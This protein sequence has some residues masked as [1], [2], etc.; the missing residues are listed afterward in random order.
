M[1]KL[2]AS[3]ESLQL[4]HPFPPSSPLYPILI[5]PSLTPPPGFIFPAKSTFPSYSSPFILMLIFTICWDPSRILGTCIRATGDRC[6]VRRLALSL[7]LPH[8]TILE[9]MLNSSLF[10]SLYIPLLGSERRRDSYYAHNT[11]FIAFYGRWENQY[12][13]HPLYLS[14]YSLMSI[15]IL[16]HSPLSLPLIPARTE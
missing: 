1:P 12:L 4:L 16:L 11:C 8:N 3:W 6:T 5:S 7:R 9:C 10:A 13:S 2:T 14:F 15:N